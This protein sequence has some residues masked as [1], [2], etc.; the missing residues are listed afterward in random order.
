MNVQ[1]DVS[2]HADALLATCPLSRLWGIS[3]CG[4]ALRV[5][6]GDVAT[7]SVAP[8]SEDDLEEAW[9]IDLLSPE[10]FS[11]VK[12]IVKLVQE[13]LKSVSLHIARRKGE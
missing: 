12:K 6:C 5:Y 3:F 7:G 9:N 1:N 2:L 8:P 11:K 13:D 4:T 10:G